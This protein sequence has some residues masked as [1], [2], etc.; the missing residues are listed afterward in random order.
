[1]EV[2]DSSKRIEYLIDV[3]KE[4]DL[5]KKE[6]I[7][8]TLMLIAD[9]PEMA[10]EDD[11]FFLEETINEE[12]KKLLENPFIEAEE[13]EQGDFSFFFEKALSERI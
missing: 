9:C 4:T 6:K 1:M 10:D 12:K 8:K 13:N 11:F 7:K 5:I 2:F 3:C